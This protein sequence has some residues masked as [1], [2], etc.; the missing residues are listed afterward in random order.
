M[1]VRVY[2][3][4]CGE[5]STS[6]APT[7]KAEPKA[8]PKASKTKAEAPKPKPTEA[9]APK[10]PAPKAKAPP[11]APTPRAE[12][13]KTAK[14]AEAEA[15]T[16]KPQPTAPPKAK[17]PEAAAPEPKA[18]PKAAA[19]AK[20]EPQ[21]AAEA[22]PKE[23]PKQSPKAPAPA[24]PKAKTVAKPK[25]QAPKPKVPAATE[26]EPKAAA[27]PTQQSLGAGK[28]G[29]EMEMRLRVLKRK[30]LGDS[31]VAATT[32]VAKLQA[33]LLRLKAEEK[34]I[35]LTTEELEAQ[36]GRVKAE[37]ETALAKRRKCEEEFGSHDRLKVLEGRPGPQYLERLFGNLAAM[38][39]GHAA[40]LVAV[41]A[42]R[43]AASCSANAVERGSLTL[44]G[45]WV[46]PVMIESVHLSDGADR[47]MERDAS[48][49]PARRRRIDWAAKSQAW[50]ETIPSTASTCSRRRELALPVHN[51]DLT[52]LAASQARLPPP[53]PKVALASCT[54]GCRPARLREWLFWHLAK[55][56]R[57]V[58][59]R[60]EG[61]MGQEQEEVIRDLR[62][63]GC[64][65]L[66]ESSLQGKA[67]SSFQRVMTRQ[68]RFVHKAIRAA[69]ARRCDFL[70]HLDDDELLF[71]ETGSIPT[72]LR[73]YVGSSKRLNSRRVG[74]GAQVSALRKPGGSFSL[75]L[76]DG[77]PLLAAP[78]ALQ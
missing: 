60:W 17:A 49:P 14:K 46:T 55:G 29:E 75:R 33:R 39:V 44:Y 74:V 13:G 61:A 47:P 50:Q 57:L 72:L 73:Q 23:L 42:P 68:I 9:A 20:A 11:T 8:E 64:L 56:I 32:A 4:I 25:A 19:K 16:P 26:K 5:A 48:K 30:L 51:E 37:L 76:S 65:I 66:L 58:L 77:V 3:C 59:L 69:R 70:L 1:F 53:S 38:F 78:H 10:P 43:I 15:E 52:H 21:P 63:S 18:E 36:L 45:S 22:A 41:N 2:S 71:P 27:P 67:S 62:D 7:P 35:A 24:E 54:R 31:A 6:V 28:N 40:G 12:P 34:T